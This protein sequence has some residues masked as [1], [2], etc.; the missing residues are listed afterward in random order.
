MSGNQYAYSIEFRH[1]GNLHLDLVAKNRKTIRARLARLVNNHTKTHYVAT[2]KHVRD[3]TL[4]VFTHG[5][6]RCICDHY[7]MQPHPHLEIKSQIEIIAKAWVIKD[8][9]PE[10]PVR[11]TL[12][13]RMGDRAW[14]DPEKY[15][16]P[17]LDGRV[18]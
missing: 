5:K 16:P 4:A 3:L 12:K 17:P 9:K 1:G 8:A 15:P 7:F 14:K 6:S 11:G 18:T 10:G 13:E 2:E